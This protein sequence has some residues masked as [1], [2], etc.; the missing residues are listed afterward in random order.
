MAL[1]LPTSSA[2]II[3]TTPNAGAVVIDATVAIAICAREAGRE[4]K[5]LA[6]IGDYSHHATTSTRPG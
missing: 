6:E 4:P 2:A 3:P 1:N 5:A